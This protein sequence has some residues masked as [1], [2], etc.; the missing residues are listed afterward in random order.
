MFFTVNEKTR[1]KTYVFNQQEC[2][3][4]VS[5]PHRLAAQGLFNRI[6]GSHPE[7]VSLKLGREGSRGPA[8]SAITYATSGYIFHRYVS[9]LG[10]LTRYTHVIIDEVHERSVEND[11]V[12]LI[13]Q[14]LL[15]S[16]P[17][18]KVVLMSATP[19]TEV[20][21]EY[22]GEFGALAMVNGTKHFILFS[23]RFS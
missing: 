23:L 17:R 4:L 1:L 20:F 3:I 18:V 16:D 5:E 13:V 6:S 15:R 7:L 2:C 10:D 12:F 11:L 19:H 14:H 8:N 21:H 22:Y 9:K